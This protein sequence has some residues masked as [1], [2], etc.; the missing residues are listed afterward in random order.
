[1]HGVIQAGKHYILSKGRRAGQKVTISKV[2]D[3]RYVVVKTEK[4][5]ERKCSVN[6]LI[7]AEHK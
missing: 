3:E 4:G 6:H 2:V 5:T 1:M 7:P